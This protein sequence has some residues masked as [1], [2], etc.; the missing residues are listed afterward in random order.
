MKHIK[1]LSKSMPAKATLS[2]IIKTF[3]Q[4]IKDLISPT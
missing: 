2:D 4:D 3:I 1:V